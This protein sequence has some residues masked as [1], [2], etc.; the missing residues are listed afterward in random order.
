VCCGTRR[1]GTTCGFSRHWSAPRRTD[2]GLR[3]GHG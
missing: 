3:S 1:L 2:S